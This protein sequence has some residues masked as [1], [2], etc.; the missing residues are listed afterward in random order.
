METRTVSVD[1]GKML[2]GVEY[3]FASSHRQAE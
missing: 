2:K 3:L 1:L